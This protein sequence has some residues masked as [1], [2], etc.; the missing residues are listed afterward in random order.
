MSGDPSIRLTNYTTQS[1]HLQHH[2]HEENKGKEIV[3]AIGN[4][5]VQD[6]KK[7]VCDEKAVD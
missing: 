1:Q 4:K 6:K 2:L 3:Q 7:G 5:K